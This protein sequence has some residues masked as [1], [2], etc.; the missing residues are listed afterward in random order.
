MVELVHSTQSKEC[1][2]AS[3]PLYMIPRF[4]SAAIIYL[5]HAAEREVRK[6]NLL[7]LFLLEDEEV[8]EVEAPSLNEVLM[9]DGSSEFLLAN[10]DVKEENE[11]KYCLL[12][13][14]CEM[15]QPS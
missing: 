7:F 8:L 12:V 11:E 5:P 2:P 1:S 10:I 9:E 15:P 6:L 13:E 4:A 14:D 3:S